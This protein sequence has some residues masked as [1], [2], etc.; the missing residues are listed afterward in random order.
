MYS[1][2]HTYQHAESAAYVS[3]AIISLVGVY[4]FL[5]L[6]TCRLSKRDVAVAVPVVA[7]LVAAGY[8]GWKKFK[9]NTDGKSKPAKA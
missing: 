5:L 8:F 7:L 4:V 3:V 9:K 2:L 1:S 6:L